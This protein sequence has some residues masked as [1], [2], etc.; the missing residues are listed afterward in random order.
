[1]SEPRLDDADERR[2][3][4]RD[5]HTVQYPENRMVA[6]LDFRDHISAAIDAL[7]KHGFLPSEIEVYHGLSA[8]KTL[9]AS[10]GRTGIAH[11][12]MRF[13]E[14]LHMPNDELALKHL[15]ADAL[16][17]GRFVVSVLAPSE[18]RQRLAAKLLREHGGGNVHFYSRYTITS[19]S[20]AD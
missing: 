2:A 18:E 10:T 7:T 11:V 6:I 14:A 12:A 3:R 13:V 9:Q 19:P 15:Y 1:M 8:A 17:E 20:R 16:A 5:E 4:A